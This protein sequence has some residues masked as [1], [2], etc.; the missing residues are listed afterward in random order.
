MAPLTQIRK[1]ESHL[2]T[3]FGKMIVSLYK[4]KR[5]LFLKATIFLDDRAQT[6]HLHRHLQCIGCWLFY[7]NIIF[8][9]MKKYL[10]IDIALDPVKAKIPKTLTILLTQNFPLQYGI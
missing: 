9:E 3:V 1:K 2:H 4:E 7:A 5:Q 6:T 8:F 10:H